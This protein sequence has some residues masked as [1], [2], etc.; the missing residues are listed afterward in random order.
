M[1]K[2]TYLLLSTAVLALGTTGCSKSSDPTPAAQPTLQPRDYQVEYR[3][4]S[5]TDASVDYVS[6]RND[7]GGLTTLG[8]TALPATYFFKRNM[9]RGDDLSILASLPGGSASSD[10]TTTILLDGKD[11]KKTVGHGAKSQAVVVYI[12]GE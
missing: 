11:V 8:T 5:T 9:K 12:I 4:S 1:K 6:Y 7:S 10:I 2:L 3:V